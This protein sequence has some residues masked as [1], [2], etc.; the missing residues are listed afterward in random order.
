MFIY[1]MCYSLCFFIFIIFIIIFVVEDPN[2]P[3]PLPD[4]SDGREVGREATTCFGLTEKIFGNTCF[5][6]MVELWSHFCS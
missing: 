5:D 4:I 6:Y 1:A 3:L 2:G